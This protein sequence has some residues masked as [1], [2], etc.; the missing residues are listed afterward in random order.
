M[1]VVILAAGRGTRMG[2]LT[3]TRPKPMLSYAG[4]NLIEHKLEI[5]PDKTKEIVI[6]V[7]YLGDV[8]KNHFGDNWKNIPIRYVEQKELNGTGGAIW[9]AQE[10]LENTPFLIMPGD[11]IF[12]KEDIDKIIEHERSMLV[13]H[14]KHGVV[15]GGNVKRDEAG[16]L[17]AIIEG[18]HDAP[19][20]IATSLY[21]L[22]D[23]IFKYPLVKI[24][25]RE[26]YGLPQTI[27]PYSKEYPIHI[28]EE[29]GWKQITAPEDLT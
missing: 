17:L 4:K 11:D 10:H 15:S 27:V 7:G 18:K 28:V 23:N 29:T 6:V 13:S 9:T 8:I 16:K 2:N 24:P 19:A 12:K 1:K 14:I 20:T 21:F 22:D 25:G 5:I 3:D 26:E